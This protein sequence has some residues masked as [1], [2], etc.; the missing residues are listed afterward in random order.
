MLLNDEEIRRQLPSGIESDGSISRSTVTHHHREIA[1][2]QA[3]KMVEWLE[4]DCP[5]DTSFE[6][7]VRAKRLHCAEC[8]QALLDEVK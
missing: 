2:A 5:H 3:K 7:Y 4:E 6:V 1:K 8:W